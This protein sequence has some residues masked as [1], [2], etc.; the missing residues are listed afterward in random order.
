MRATSRREGAAYHRDYDRTRRNSA[1][2]HWYQYKKREPR[3]RRIKAKLRPAP[4]HVFWT[5][6][7]QLFTVRKRNTQ[8]RFDKGLRRGTQ[9]PVRNRRIGNDTYVVPLRVLLGPVNL[10]QGSEPRL[11]VFRSHQITFAALNSVSVFCPSARCR[12][13]FFVQLAHS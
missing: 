7:A 6:T 2:C 3:C 1:I 4:P 12:L 11:P 9:P 8:L 10:L 13:H 5:V